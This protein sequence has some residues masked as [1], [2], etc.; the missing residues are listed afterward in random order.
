MPPT[1]VHLNGSINLPDSDA[2]FRAL[3]ERIGPLAA[4]YPDGETGDRSNWIWFQLQRFWETPGLERVSDTDAA[5]RYGGLPKVRL[6]DG[7]DPA[8]V[9]WPNLGYADAYLAS[10]ERFIALRDA[11]VIPAGTRYQVQYPTPL[12]SINSW[13]VPED[14]DALEASYRR[15]LYADLD[16]LLAAL[17]HDQFAVQWDVAVEFAILTGSFPSTGTQTFETVVARLAECVG[18]VP[19][20]V[21]VGLHL[22]YGDYQH[23]HFTQPESIELQ[24]RVANRL[25]A[26]AR[27]PIAWFAFTVPQDQRSPAYFAALGDL[28]VRGGTELYFALVPYHPDRP[29]PGTTDAQVRIIDGLLVNH[30]GNG[31]VTWGVCTE[32]GMGRVDREDTLRLLD[33]HREIAAGVPV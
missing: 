6:A 17:P 10:W 33:L 16:R 2:V 18:R 29:A 3:G 15:A 1:R 23:Q 8:A 19:P 32:C 11:G 31:H 21:P 20:E 13:I 27:R 22:C 25:A 26:E 4:R 24:V 28:R 14:Q 5:A 30:P 12:A 9:A 7:V